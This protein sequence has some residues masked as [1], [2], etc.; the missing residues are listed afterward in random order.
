M[1]DIYILLHCGGNKKAFTEQDP[2]VPAQKKV[3]M[4][5]ARRAHLHQA[6]GDKTNQGLENNLTIQV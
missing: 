5:S 3:K 2:T 4:V 1:Y 6:M